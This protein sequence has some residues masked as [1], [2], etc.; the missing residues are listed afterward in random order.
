MTEIHSFLVCL[1]ARRKE[2]GCESFSSRYTGTC[3]VVLKSINNQYLP[4]FDALGFF[5]ILGAAGTEGKVDV[6]GTWFNNS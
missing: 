1:V 5:F 3:V 4:F 2:G 6:A